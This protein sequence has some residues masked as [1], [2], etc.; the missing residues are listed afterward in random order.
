VTESLVNSDCRKK[1]SLLSQSMSAGIAAQ[2]SRSTGL[3]ILQSKFRASRK[4]KTG[5]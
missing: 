2:H 5:G 3:A 1:Y 4:E